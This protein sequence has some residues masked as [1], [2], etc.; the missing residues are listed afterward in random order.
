MIPVFWRYSKVGHIPIS[1]NDVAKKL[2][3]D[4][5]VIHQLFKEWNEA[6]QPNIYRKKL[7]PKKWIQV[8]IIEG[9]NLGWVELSRPWGNTWRRFTDKSQFLTF[10]V[11]L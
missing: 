2:E 9:Q 5:C 3:V 8:F 7:E 1:V 11:S 10:E 6:G 4:P